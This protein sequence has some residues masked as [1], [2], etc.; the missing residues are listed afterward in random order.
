MGPSIFRSQPRLHTC[1]IQGWFSN[2]DGGLG[3]TPEK[4][5]FYR[6]LP[7]DS[8]HDSPTKKVRDIWT[9]RM[10]CIYQ[11]D[12]IL[13]SKHFEVLEDEAFEGEDAKEVWLDGYEFPGRRSVG[14]QRGR[15]ADEV[16]YSWPFYKDKILNYDMWREM[17]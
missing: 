10:D 7:H 11:D 5:V 8:P 14:T 12:D 2:C 16:D 13:V 15:M 1:D 3:L 9:S 17:D 6:R 4:A